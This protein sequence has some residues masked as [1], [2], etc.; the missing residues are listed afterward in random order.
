[1][2]K[3]PFILI[4]QKQKPKLDQRSGA[5]LKKT[6]VAWITA[7]I[8]VGAL[9]LILAVGLLI[10]RF[11]KKYRGSFMA[12]RDENGMQYYASVHSGY[13]PHSN[14]RKQARGNTTDV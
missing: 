14:S 9:V 7:G 12:P 11:R 2:Y 4:L 8:V 6:S 3:N 13:H 1:M 5:K 10:H